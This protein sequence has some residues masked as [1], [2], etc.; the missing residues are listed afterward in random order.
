MIED[1]EKEVPKEGMD[2]GY[3]NTLIKY[4]MQEDKV[5]KKVSFGESHN[6]GEV[7]YA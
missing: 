6:G 2:D 7:F 1:P 4:D 5:V 3:F